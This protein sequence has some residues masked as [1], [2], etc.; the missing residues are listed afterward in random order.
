MQASNSNPCENWVKKL[1]N[2][3]LGNLQFV[4]VKVAQ[5]VQTE[6]NYETEY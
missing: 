2:N 6:K 1:S 3:K 4:Q 5:K